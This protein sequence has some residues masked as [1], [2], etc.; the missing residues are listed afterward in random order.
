MDLVKTGTAFL[1]LDAARICGV[2]KERWRD[3]TFPHGML[4]RDETAR[5]DRLYLI[6][7]P[8][9]L[10][11]ERER[12]RFEE[13]NRLILENF[14]RPDSLLEVGC[15]E[16]LQSCDLQQ[17]CDRLC[18]IDVS[19]RAVRRARRR[20]PHATFAVA[21]VYGLPQFPLVTR[22]DL[23]IACEVLYYM[24][25]VA[26]ALNRL[27]E[28]GRACLISYYDGAR[29]GLDKH[30]SEIPGVRFQTVPYEDVSWTVAWWRP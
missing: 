23:V 1:G 13:T 10:N 30:V 17:L 19:G 3:K 12:F 7:D 9:S 14:G 6:R 28:L 29:E 8:W 24:A 20:C 15:G 22:F 2:L 21:D 5:F 11:C 4:Y 27:S 18:G 25:D 16:G 26:S